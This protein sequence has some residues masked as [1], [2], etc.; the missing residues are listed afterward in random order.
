MKKKTSC[1]GGFLPITR[2]SFLAGAGTAAALPAKPAFAASYP[3]LSVKPIYGPLRRDAFGTAL[4]PKLLAVRLRLSQRQ[5]NAESANAEPLELTIHLAAFAPENFDDPAVKMTLTGLT[6]LRPDTDSAVSLDTTLEI[7]IEGVDLFKFRLGSDAPTPIYYSFCVFSQTQS[8]NVERVWK[9]QLQSNAWGFVKSSDE[10][11]K[12][13]LTYT[14]YHKFPNSLAPAVLPDLAD[15]MRGEAGFSRDMPG[16][17]VARMLDPLLG[18]SVNVKGNF[19]ATLFAD[20]PSGADE[21]AGYRAWTWQAQ[22]MRYK[23][24]RW[25]IAKESLVCNEISFGWRPARQ[26]LPGEAPRGPVFEIELGHNTATPEKIVSKF[27]ADRVKP[28]GQVSFE[29]IDYSGNEATR[30][31]FGLNSGTSRNLSAHVV[32]ETVD[33]TEGESDPHR[34]VRLDLTGEVALTI[35]DGALP[36]GTWAVSLPPHEGTLDAPEDDAQPAFKM[37][38]DARAEHWQIDL[39][40]G[41]KTAVL[42]AN[43]SW[44]ITTKCVATVDSLVP[45]AAVVPQGIWSI[46]TRTLGTIFLPTVAT[47]ASFRFRL[48]NRVIRRFAGRIP[49]LSVPALPSRSDADPIFARSEA[50]GDGVSPVI[51]L[52]G[53]EEP[54]DFAELAP[55]AGR[56]LLDAAPSD[57]TA[58]DLPAGNVR[59]KL[60]RA[61]DMLALDFRFAG[62]RLQYTGRPGVFDLATDAAFADP[63]ARPHGDA[64]A[65]AVAI[66][67]P[68]QHVAE[69]AYFRQ[70]SF[71]KTVPSVDFIDLFSRYASLM[72]KVKKP[73]NDTA[74]PAAPDSQADEN[75]EVA[76]TPDMVRATL[77]ALRK[78][79]RFT[80]TQRRK[81]LREALGALLAALRAR[82]DAGETSAELLGDIDAI[83]AVIDFETTLNKAAKGLWPRLPSDQMIFIG[84]DYLDPDGAHVGWAEVLKT[85]HVELLQ[86]LIGRLLSVEAD[87]KEPANGSE[88]GPFAVPDDLQKPLLDLANLA[89][90]DTTD[91]PR[92]FI[93]DLVLEPERTVRRVLKAGNQPPS[94]LVRQGELMSVKRSVAADYAAFADFWDNRLAAATPPPSDASLDR[95]GD[96]VALRQMAQASDPTVKAAFAQALWAYSDPTGATAEPFDERVRA[97][98][99]RPSRTVF[100]WDPAL[101][102]AADGM[103][104]TGKSAGKPGQT[105]D[106]GLAAQDLRAPFSVKTLLGMTQGT[107]LVTRRAEV[108]RKLR[109]DGALVRETDPAEIL[110]HQGILPDPRNEGTWAKRAAAIYESARRA[111]TAFETSIELPFRLDLSPAQD[112]VWVQPRIVPEE[113]FSPPIDAPENP[114][115]RPGKEAPATTVATPILVQDTPTASEPPEGRPIWSLSLAPR[116]PDPLLRAVW[117]EDFRPATF[118]SLTAAET[119]GELGRL[120][121]SPPKGNLTPWLLP[122]VALD[123]D[124]EPQIEEVSEKWNVVCAGGKPQ[125]P[126]FRASLDAYDRDQLVKLTSVPGIPVAGAVDPETQ[127]IRADAS[128]V[129]APDGY[130]LLDL[131]T[132]AARDGEDEPVRRR[133]ISAIYQ[134][135]TLEFKELRLS[136]MGGT[137]N[138]DTPFEP[139]AAPLSKSKRAL[140]PSMTVE[141]WRHRAVAGRD[142]QTE[143]VYKGYLFPFGIRASLVKVTERTYTDP[144]TLKRGPTA[145]L[146]QRMFITVAQPEKDT[147]YGQPDGGR[148]WPCERI[149][150]LTRKTPDIVD[151]TNSADVSALNNGVS[152]TPNGRL[153]IK[154]K[155]GNVADYPGLVFWPRVAPIRSANL[156]F[157][158]QID[159]ATDRLRMPMLFMDVEAARSDLTVAAVVDYYNG[160][161]AVSKDEMPTVSRTSERVVRHGGALRRYATE[162]ETG[163][164][165]YETEAWVIGAQGRPGPPIRPLP[166]LAD[167]TDDPTY[168]DGRTFRKARAGVLPVRAN[169]VFGP[170]LSASDQPPFYP[171]VHVAELRLDRVARLTGQRSGQVV[172]AAFGREY[173]TDGLPDPD[174][175]TPRPPQSVGVESIFGV[176]TPTRFDVGSNGDR[177]GAIGRPSG[178]IATLARREGP[179]TATS[180]L[181]SDGFHLPPELSLIFPFVAAS[182]DQQG[183]SLLIP[184]F[185]T[186]RN[187][188]HTQGSNADLQKLLNTILGDNDAKLLGVFKISEVLNIVLQSA[189]SAVPQIAEAREY[190]EAGADKILELVRA[191]IIPALKSALAEADKIFGDAVVGLGIGKLEATRVY[192]EIE[193]GL[194]RL[195]SAMTRVEKA[196]DRAEAVRRIAEIPAGGKA[197][198][199]AFDK[200]ARDPISPIKLELHRL[201]LKELS[202]IEE[203]VEQVEKIAELLRTPSTIP[204]KVEKEMIKALRDSLGDSKIEEQIAEAVL[205]LSPTLATLDKNTTLRKACADVVRSFHRDTVKQIFDTPDKLTRLR[206]IPAR[207][208]DW[209]LGKMAWKA[210]IEPKVNEAQTSLKVILEDL[211]N[212][213]EDAL[214]NPGDVAAREIRRR[215][216]PVAA[217]YWRLDTLA[218]EI[219]TSANAA[220]NQATAAARR[221]YERRKRRLEAERDRLLDEIAN[222]LFGIPALTLR[223]GFDRI[224]M[225]I[226]DVGATTRPEETVQKILLV[227]REVDTLFLSGSLAQELAALAPKAEDLAALKSAVIAPYKASVHLARSV[228]TT[229]S[230]RSVPNLNASDYFAAVKLATDEIDKVIADT[231]KTGEQI[232]NDFK[233]LDAEMEKAR[234][235][236]HATFGYAPLRVLFAGDP[237]NE[238][239][240]RAAPGLLIIAKTLVNRAAALEKTGQDA[241]IE[242][243]ESFRSRVED[244]SGASRQALDRVILAQAKANAAYSAFIPATVTADAAI[245]TF[246]A[247]ATVAKYQDAVEA[248]RTTFPKPQMLAMLKAWPT[249]IEQ[250]MRAFADLVEDARGNL[251]EISSVAQTSLRPSQILAAL[252]ARFEETRSDAERDANVSFAATVAEFEGWAEAKLA[253]MAISVLDHVVAELKRL[254]STPAELSDA[255][256][257]MKDARE[258]VVDLTRPWSISPSRLPERSARLAPRPRSCNRSL[259][260]LNFCARISTRRSTRFRSRNGSRRSKRR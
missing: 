244:Y 46:R 196:S 54:K 93:T 24:N 155:N 148:G 160:I 14:Y 186:L 4:P 23:T 174:P 224:A 76:V 188:R 62:L 78:S 158:F 50:V 45:G 176:L 250:T 252:E 133:D 259:N 33:P 51:A 60:R 232:R 87:L 175:S 80:R 226:D 88:G 193:S 34:I 197:L 117:S 173:L 216:E 204:E 198:I 86:R 122:R 112:A 120:Y 190:A 241:L 77:Q 42:Q 73:D 219:E 203:I 1:T 151:P 52:T 106:A 210:V 147:W 124:G 58:L 163:D 110:K 21:S 134:P 102:A 156:D 90:P 237:N 236:V 229:T 8:G 247:A 242:S 171:F 74:D 29:T 91:I 9:I 213:L 95:Y 97:R 3:D 191:N 228:A 127:L 225:R 222:A 109:E 32:T 230:P 157:E 22:P 209:Q 59:L 150:L 217:A 75:D 231:T 118:L 235:E 143:V 15:V 103:E 126:H 108:K 234:A 100:R 253:E 199:E 137:I 201:F 16:E 255:T 233:A 249:L 187:V 184:G 165:A 123:N 11:G 211:E 195:A 170:L 27:T 65:P 56:I 70:R 223:D 256:K 172:V 215:L 35:F 107:G 13:R 20:T 26:P 138:L 84:R 79:D 248:L 132:V 166:A 192:P 98:F 258:A 145:F 169:Y 64:R 130:A 167:A 142:I 68:S 240:A 92:K 113:L 81:T 38:A 6:G 96:Y 164:S 12:L 37:Q 154:P 246:E 243:A 179:V 159:A 221:E 257:A 194:K 139:P 141:R 200:V 48:S 61:S 99:A 89:T 71:A 227:A 128:A 94:S 161:P 144:D 168:A 251:R 55:A 189:G 245:A 129:L 177:V 25:S 185:G 53:I 85:I 119:S 57:P 44:E 72:V 238:Q 18:A 31:R 30:L 214:G 7:R 41:P 105:A 239:R 182:E 39:F 116:F 111:P 49:L 121:A 19:V 202:Q 28:S 66:E 115:S 125:W 83:E 36:V 162:I 206:D 63:D 205:S 183:A 69:Q 67:F 114:S 212:E 101:L 153:V 10:A 180:A 17:A 254:P 47:K 5:N 152:V 207:I 208:R 82:N 220:A 181:K 146:V 43:K 136:A 260:S 40:S 178:Y 135:K 218:S 140:Y 149:I 2:R 131:Q 104:E